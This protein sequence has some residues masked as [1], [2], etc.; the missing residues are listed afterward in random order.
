MRERVA[1][2]TLGLLGPVGMQ[3]APSEAGQIL[4]CDARR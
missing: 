4:G 3:N 2:L 1:L